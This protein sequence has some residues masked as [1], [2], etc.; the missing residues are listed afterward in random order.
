MIWAPEKLPMFV[1]M[2]ANQELDQ[3]A[4]GVFFH[5]CVAASGLRSL[6]GAL[7]VFADELEG[8]KPGNVDVA[9][10]DITSVIGHRMA[11]LSDA[12][13]HDRVINRWAPSFEFALFTAR[14]VSAFD[15][16]YLGVDRAELDLDEDV[17]RLEAVLRHG[18]GS[19]K[20]FELCK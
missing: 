2:E 20:P 11:T 14:M 18:W 10:W 1:A 4:K 15:G 5:A 16:S 19:D 17:L 7:D 6:M 3:E 9:L 8:L 13:L 12:A